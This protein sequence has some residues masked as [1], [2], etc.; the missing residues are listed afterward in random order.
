MFKPNFVITPEINNKI[1]EIE[2]LKT[3]FEQANILPELVVELRFRATVESVHSSTSIEGNPLNEQ[4][5]Q[6]VLEGNVVTAPEYA[7][8]EVIN[9]KNAINWLHKKEN[10][11]TT[12]NEKEILKL[13][14]LIMTNL[15]PKNKIGS[16][17]PGNIYVVDQINNKEVIQYT[18][19][20]A[21]DL[22]KLITSFFE[23]I[24]IQK[25][26]KKLHPVLLSG[27]IHYIFVS[28]HPFSDGNGR[29]T[30]LLT[31]QYLK[32]VNYN[33]ND[34]L[35]LDSYYLQNRKEYYT[36]LSRGKTF[37]S[38]MFADI[39]PFLEFFVEGFLQS[40]KSLTKYVQMGKIVDG[41]QKPIKLN[42]E[43]LLILDYVYQFK[44]IS[45]EEAIT[46]TGAAK[47]TVQR[48]LSGLVT[49][50]IL[51][52]KGKGPATRYSLLTKECICKK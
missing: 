19:P 39:T 15:L 30:R 44:S 21:K 45:L 41:T 40:L 37:E 6:K 38:R 13:H 22:K 49:K 11:Q 52:N 29:T 46:A 2:K 36:A 25:N 47:R 23:W 4:E 20:D 50:G 8:Q 48:R 14:A 17:R 24:T 7:I 1:A 26:E 34:S 10:L 43:E 12:L 33:F 42:Q 35:S 3:L 28:I 27:L 32:S 51:I 31:N 16:F 9:Y 5:V 18:G